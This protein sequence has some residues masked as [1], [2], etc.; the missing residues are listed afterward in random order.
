MI[1]M[2]PFSL[3]LVCLCLFH[4]SSSFAD[5][6]RDNRARWRSMSREERQRVIENYRQWK[7]QPPK[8]REMTR[9]NYETYHSMPPQERRLLRDRFDNYRRLDDSGR[10]RVV[11]RLKRM[12]S[13][14]PGEKADIIAKYN[15]IK[16]RPVSERMRLLERSPFWQRLDEHDQE[17]FRRLLF[18]APPSRRY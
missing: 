6:S 11:E 17:M 3:L 16:D 2:A 18:P 10:E 8:Q 7:A 14:S 9:R 15:R 12:D 13:L 4:I 1:R 5:D